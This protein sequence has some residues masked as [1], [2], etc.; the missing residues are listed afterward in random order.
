MY[1]MYYCVIYYNHMQQKK[2]I[3]EKILYLMHGCTTPPI[4]YV[5]GRFRMSVLYACG[6]G[7]RAHELDSFPVGRSR[8]W[9]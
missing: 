1:K 7:V 6:V 4:T 3:R 2:K 5:T 9:E 8:L